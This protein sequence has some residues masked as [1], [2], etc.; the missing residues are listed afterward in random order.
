[1]KKICILPFM[2]T[3]IQPDGR[4]KLCC[5]S[6]NENQMPSVSEIG[7]DNILNNKHHVSIRKAMLNGE[8]P[9]VCKR[10]WKNESLGIESY[11]QQQFKTYP[12][13]IL[14]I[15]NTNK[16]G[17]ISNGVKYLDVRFNNTC[18]LKCIN[19]SSEYSTSW[20]YDERK[21]VELTTDEK[22]KEAIRYRVDVYDKESYKWSRDKEI[23]DSIIANA[24]SLDRLHFAGGE[25]LL[26][27]QHVPLLKELIKLGFHKNLFLSYNT[28]GEFID[29]DLLDLWSNFKRVKIFYSLDHVYEKNEYLRFP[30]KWTTVEEKFDLIERASPSN[31]DWRLL[32]TVN[33]MNILYLPEFVDWKL[34]Q[35]F[36]KIHNSWLDGKLCH[37]MPVDYP[38][39]LHAGVL[40]AHIKDLVHTKLNKHINTLPQRYRPN[41]QKIINDNISFMQE[42]DYSFLLD[43]F[44]SL[45]KNID[46]IRGTNFNK[47]FPELAA[48]LN[49]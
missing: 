44:K 37:A 32:T 18:N 9:E 10:C 36:K 45:I 3:L 42:T 4:I 34:E 13:H 35:N 16:D 39:Y 30:S 43:T 19:C 20:V 38:R 21:I 48:E 33:A 46:F 8:Q 49:P 31:I 25:P 14:K 12:Q 5:N 6:E 28:N 40:P 11:R 27:K 47:V 1:M 2:H 17:V 41:Y 23:F 22:L 29:Q 15:F 24:S 26:S 7:I